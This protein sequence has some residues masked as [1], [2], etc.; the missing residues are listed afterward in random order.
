MEK[1]SYEDII[2]LPHHGSATRPQMSLL[3]RAAQFAPFAALTGYGDAIEETA[4]LTERRIELSEEEKAEL[5]AKLAALQTRLP[6]GASVTYFVPD[7]YK[8]GGRY[9]T[10]TLSV[11]RILPSDGCLLLSDGRTIDL[12][13]VLD[14]EPVEDGMPD[15]GPGLDE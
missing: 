12:D 11:R 9:V 6:V 15:A 4:R 2:D 1:R 10:R 14:V 13:C 7:R 3:N 5:G 8:E